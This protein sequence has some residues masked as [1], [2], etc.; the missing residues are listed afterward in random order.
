MRNR[1]FIAVCLLLALL[2]VMFL[3]LPLVG[4]FWHVGLLNLLRAFLDPEVLRSILLTLGIALA[5]VMLA[6]VTGIPLAYLLARYN[7]RGKSV[8]EAVIDIPVMVP[9]TAAGIAL[10]LA[11]TR[12]GIRAALESMGLSF[13]DSPLGIMAAMSFLSAPL[14]INGAKEGFRKIDVRYEKA[15]RTLGASRAAAFVSVALPLARKDIVNG[16]LM[17]WSR[18]LGEFGAVVVIAY[19]PMVAPVLIYDRFNSFGL[20]YSAP[21]AAAMI[22]I[23][24]LIFLLVR[25]LN[26][27]GKS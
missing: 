26:N 18:G 23:S 10:L 8:I 1:V 14:L 11:F 7:F 2:M 5:G 27:R 20:R 12:P 13:M 17:M 3:A 15:A 16:G 22:A 19:H 6:G 4:L 9:H 25:L 24:I 21:V